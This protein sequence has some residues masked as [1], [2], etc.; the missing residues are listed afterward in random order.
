MSTIQDYATLR[1]IKNLSHFTRESNLDSI[2]QRGLITRDLLTQEGYD[3]FNDHVRAD[4]TN[5]VCLT[6]GF[7]NYKMWYQLKMQ[8]PGVDWVIVAVN[9]A[10]LWMLQCAFCTTNAA[11]ASVS[12]IPIA[13]RKTLAAFQA[14]YADIPGKERVK[15]GIADSFPT[16]PQA[17]VLM[18]QGVPR[19][20]I[21]GL[22]AS[23]IEQE[24]RLKDKYP[25][26]QVIMKPNYFSYRNDW[27]YWKKVP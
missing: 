24:K 2:L 19:E 17:E 26:F 7:P 23:S 20:Y 18:L 22:I 5:A 6:I 14:M 21:L 3:G 15:L 25:K 1:G 9:P 27:S 11:L 12:A 10:A 8:N 16:D 13:Q 4:G